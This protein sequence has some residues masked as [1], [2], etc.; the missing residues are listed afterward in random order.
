MIKGFAQEECNQLKYVLTLD[1]TLYNS[2]LQ[3]LYCT[4]Q[5]LL[6]TSSTSNVASSL[7][8]TDCNIELYSIFKTS[9]ENKKF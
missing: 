8:H 1:N 7:Q 6:S 5:C 2:N 3:F 4:V 9:L